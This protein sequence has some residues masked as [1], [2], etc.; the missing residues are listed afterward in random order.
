MVIGRRTENSGKFI[1]WLR[2]LSEAC[3]NKNRM[4]AMR[5]LEIG[6]ALGVLRLDAAFSAFALANVPPKFNVSLTK[7]KLRKRCRDDT[8]GE[9]VQYGE[10]ER[11][12]A[13]KCLYIGRLRSLTLPVLHL[14]SNLPAVSRDH[15]TP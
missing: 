11:P 6:G 13:S 10:R 3:A 2:Y 5:Y 4:N 1:D 15:R 12:R 7:A 14:R 9:L 8:A